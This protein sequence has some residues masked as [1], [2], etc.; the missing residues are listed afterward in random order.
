MRCARN[1]LTTELTEDTER[2]ERVQFSIIGNT[3]IH[4]H[5]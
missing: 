4:Q 5:R 2:R 1:K 3:L